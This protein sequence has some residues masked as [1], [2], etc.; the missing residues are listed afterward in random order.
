MEVTKSTRHSK[1]TGDFAEALV[2]YW[3]SKYGFECARVDHTGIDVIARNPHTGEVM[4]ISVKAR[5]RNAGTE[6][7]R[8]DADAF[9]KADAAC[10]AFGCVPYFAIMVDAASTICCYIVSERH[11]L[12]LHPVASVCSSWSMTPSWVERYAADPHIQS[13]SFQTETHRWWGASAK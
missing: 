2:L 6:N 5:C 1:L 11:L 12:E 8:I 3:L 9:E 7:V 4:G 10:E 13:F